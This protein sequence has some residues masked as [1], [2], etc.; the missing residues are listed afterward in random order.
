MR[1]FVLRYSWCVV[2]Y[3]MSPGL[4]LSLSCDLHPLTP[5]RPGQTPPSPLHPLC[6]TS[7]LPVFLPPSFP[8]THSIAVSL[9]F[10][11]ISLSLA[12]CSSHSYTHTHTFCLLRLSSW[13]FCGYITHRVW[14]IV[15]GLY[16][17]PHC[18]WDCYVSIRPGHWGARSMEACWNSRL[19]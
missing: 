11:C 8:P 3:M 4:S 7:P 5:P 9:W 6:L 2:C 12:L 10:F 15:S 19:C 16:T 14:N 1:V 18:L 13:R 17:P